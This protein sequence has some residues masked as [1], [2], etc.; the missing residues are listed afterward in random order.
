[1]VAVFGGEDALRTR[2]S[3][4]RAGAEQLDF[5]GLDEL[6]ELA[7]RYENGWRPERDAEE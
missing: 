2:L 5:D 4:L 6:L 1:L 3:E 7:D